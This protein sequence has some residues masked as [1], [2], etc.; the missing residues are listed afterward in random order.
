EGEFVCA[1]WH[2]PDSGI[3]EPRTPPRE[4][5]HSKVL[6]WAALDRLLDLDARGLLGRTPRER[7]AHH[8]EQLRGSIERRGYSSHLSSYTQVFDADGADASSL[9]LVWYGYRRA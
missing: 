5:T 3:C 7:F 1:H 9:Q 2:E 8:R 6:C 4:Y